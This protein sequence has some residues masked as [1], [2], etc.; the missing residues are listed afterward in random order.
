M[1]TTTRGTSRDDHVIL[2]DPLLKSSC[3]IGENTANTVISGRTVMVDGEEVTPKPPGVVVLSDAK[4]TVVISPPPPAPPSV[5]GV[6]NGHLANGQTTSEDEEEGSV[7]EEIRADNV[8]LKMVNETA[9]FL[10][11]EREYFLALLEE[12]NAVSEEGE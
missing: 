6:Q 8:F 10:S 11:A 12:A 5:E 9:E 2:L 4:Q 3:T 7:D 1:T